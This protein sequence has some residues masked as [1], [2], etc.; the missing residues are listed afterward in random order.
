[1]TVTQLPQTADN[2]HCMNQLRGLLQALT[3]AQYRN[4]HDGQSVG[5]HVRHILDHYQC[6]FHAWQSEEVL[7]Y[8]Q[9][10]RRPELETDPQIALAKTDELI[11]RLRRLNH[12]PPALLTVRVREISDGAATLSG[13][14]L[15]R[16]LAFLASHCV[17]HLAIIKLLT[18]LGGVSL[19]AE[20]GVHPA[21]LR[22]WAGQVETS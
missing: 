3:T 6:L 22:Y 9:R 1:M 4:V 11:R 20:L 16:E 15:V 5:Q 10:S 19:P 8:E 18:A 17:H 21:T 7:D 2:L 13:S 14:S 12:P